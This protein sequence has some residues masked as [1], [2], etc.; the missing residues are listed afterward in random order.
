[1]GRVFHWF[2][3]LP[4][5]DALM[6]VAAGLLA[7]VLIREKLGDG[8]FWRWATGLLLFCW[9]G[10]ILLGTLGN[11]SASSDLAEPWLIPFYTYQ[12]AA[13]GVKELYRSNF[14]NAVLFLPAG[15]F[16]AETLPQ[17]SKRSGRVLLS[18]AFCLLLSVGI[19]ML[20]YVFCLGH[21]ETDDVIHN[22]LG[23]LMGA[24]ASFV[25]QEWIFRKK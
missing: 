3:C 17:G 2:Y 25:R 18:V 22:T 15:L 6:W 5:G 7:F 12:L 9:V 8:R 20:Q 13:G 16:L 10:I 21:V 1:M 14:M 4:I 11:R 19:E 24:V 23:G